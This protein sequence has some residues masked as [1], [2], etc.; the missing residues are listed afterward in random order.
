MDRS[1]R[2]AHRI[3]VK[4][5]AL[6]MVMAVASSL[7]S[8][9]IV[10]QVPGQDLP[11]ALP[12]M[13]LRGD[14]P[15]IALGG[16]RMDRGAA[17]LNEAP[18]WSAARMNGVVADPAVTALV[19]DLGATDFAQRD[20]ATTALRDAKVPDEQ[21]WIHLLSTPGGLSY[22]AHARL[23]DI[24][25]TRIKDAPRG[26]LGI[27]MAGGRMGENNGVTVTALI[28]NM[29]AQKVLRPGDRIVELDGKPI[30]V[31][32]QL[33]TIVQTKR[34]GERIAL[35]VMRGQRDAAGR[36]VGGPDGRPVET[37]HELEIEVGSRADLEKF[38][39]GGMDAPV[40]D[41][42][43]DRMSELLLE[44]FPAP[45][46]MIR[47]ERVPGELIAVDSH[48]DIIQLQAQLARPDGL[49]LGAGVRSVLRARLDSLEASARAPGLTDN[50]RAWFQ[51]VV[52][53]Y[54]ELIPEELRPE[55]T[56]VP[57]SKSVR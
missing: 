25:Y 46:R 19:R 44:T 54:R 27:Q 26:A 52:E 53:R 47:M 4:G 35:V 38:G 42:G 48:P 40:F 45:V 28:P 5:G 31:S 6:A 1:E 37:R 10:P 3:A 24:G 49:G 2:P 39:D 14:F 9:Q 51:A 43:R 7:G 18:P 11:R 32:E 21:I 20:A 17:S 8:Q 56:S 41:R 50:E 13:K 34:P 55:S 29:P 33:S 30:Q 22:E 36:V 15:G 23:L 57:Q 16:G 12:P